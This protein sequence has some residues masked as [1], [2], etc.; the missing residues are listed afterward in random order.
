[1]A[2]QNLSL[3]KLKEKHEKEEWA[4]QTEDVKTRKQNQVFMLLGG[5]QVANKISKS[6][7]SQIMNALITFQEE[8]MYLNLGFDNF[9]DFMQNS[10][11][12]PFK[13]SE[14]YKRRDIY[15][16]EGGQ[17]F[18]LMNEIGVSYSVRKQLAA[19]NY[20]AISFEGDKIRVGDEEAD[21][22]NMRMV[23]TLIESFADEARKNRDDA[24]RKQEKLERAE[25]QVTKLSGELSSLKSEDSE[26]TRIL[27]AYLK[28]E[29]ALEG[30]IK[31][32]K[33][34]T[35]VNREKSADVYVRGIYAR[36]CAVKQVFGRGDMNLEESKVEGEFK[37]VLSR[38]NDDELAGLME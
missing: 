36:F 8:E 35:L 3:E 14:F 24:Q 10:E 12:A 18:D 15:L 17:L 20:D 1:M 2:K 28:A 29:N 22:S 26:A 4:L 38:M 30:L 21:L 11:Y 5:I 19:G 37:N 7:D 9:A 34:S 33:A 13:K 31:A 32:V 27:E 25:Q 6:I 16:A 23:K